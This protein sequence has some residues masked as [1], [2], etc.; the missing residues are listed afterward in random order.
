MT[1]DNSAKKSLMFSK[2]DDL[3]FLSYNILLILQGLK[4]ICGKKV[5]R[6][7]RKLAFLVDFVANRNLAATLTQNGRMLNE[8]DRELFTRA[9]AEGLLR[10]NQIIRLLFTLEKQGIVSLTRDG[11]KNVID[12]CLKPTDQLQSFFDKSLFQAE[13]RNLEIIRQAVSHL[14]T[15]S[16]ETLLIRLF[17]K[18]GIKT[19]DRYR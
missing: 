9:Y 19:W 17:E 10:L 1:R 11:E 12:V 15:L 8:I 16:L 5:F 18:H 6:D 3:Y 7:Y 2:G 13:L 14:N 4:C